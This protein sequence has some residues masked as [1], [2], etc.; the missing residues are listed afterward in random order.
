MSGHGGRRRY[1]ALVFDLGGVVVAH[2]NQ[3][4]FRRLASRCRDECSLD[5]VEQICSRPEYGD[6]AAAIAALHAEFQQLFGYSGDWLTFADDWCCHLSVDQSMLTFV[7]ELSASNRVLLF[8]NTNKVHWDFLVAATDG[9]LARFEAYLSHEIGQSKPDARAFERV[10]QAARIEPAASVF[11][12]DRLENEEAARLAGFEA[13]V[14]R[15]EPWL[16]RYLEGAM[17]G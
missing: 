7:T 11:F 10:V 1:E 8:S 6:G 4:L 5:R 2:D 9:R 14:F 17:S 12:D 3:V 16:R 15:G 13:E